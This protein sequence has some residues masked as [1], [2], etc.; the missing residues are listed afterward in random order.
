MALKNLESQALTSSTN[1]I[2]TAKF[3]I[4]DVIK[5]REVSNLITE[6]LKIV[7]QSPQVLLIKNQQVTYHSSHENIHW[8]NISNSINKP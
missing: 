3:Y 8:N 4:I 2:D 5:H 6:K 7:H 1:Q